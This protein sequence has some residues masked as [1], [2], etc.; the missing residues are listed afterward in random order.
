M[1]AWSPEELIGLSWNNKPI[2]QENIIKDY[3]KENKAVTF[4]K[5]WEKDCAIIYAVRDITLA[6]A[7]ILSYPVEKSLHITKNTLRK[8]R[9]TTS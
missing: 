2:K 9:K 1:F 4:W 7:Y 6:V 5:E 8:L 3:F